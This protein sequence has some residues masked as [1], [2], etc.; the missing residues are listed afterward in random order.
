MDRKA[1]GLNGAS[2]ACLSL[3]SIVQILALMSRGFVLKGNGLLFPL[4]NLEKR[5]EHLETVHCDFKMREFITE[6]QAGTIFC[7]NNFSRDCLC[8]CIHRRFWQ[9]V[10]HLIAVC[11]LKIL[12][13][14][15]PTLHLLVVKGAILILQIKLRMKAV[16]FL[17]QVK[18]PCKLGLF[19]DA[20]RWESCDKLKGTSGQ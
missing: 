16:G 13:P 15:R 5:R 18:H 8:Q 3:D 9:T 19:I 11:L 1:S 7:H 4:V 2:L 6:Y 17:I 20:H 10:R 14:S 12:Q